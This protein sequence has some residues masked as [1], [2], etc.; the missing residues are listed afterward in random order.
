MARLPLPRNPAQAV[1]AGFAAAILIG[2]AL[3]M[4]PG[5]RAGAGG[6]PLEVAMFTA[7]SAVCVTG[8]T[9]VDTAVYWSDLGHAII[10]LLIQV[11]G[12]GIVTSAALL[13]ILVG[14]RIGLRTSILTQAEAGALRLGD[15]RRV[16]LGVAVLTLAAEVATTLV[17]AGRFWLGYHLG[18]G[19]ALWQGAFH[20]ISAYNN[21][22][23]ALFSDSLVGFATDGWILV[24]IALAVIIGSLGF[25]VWLDLWRLPA[26]PRRWSLHT[27][28]TLVATA[29]LIVLGTAAMWLFEWNHPETLGGVSVP[30]RLLVGFFNAVTPRTAGFNAVDYADLEPETLFVTDILMFIGGGAGSTAGGIKTATLALL[31]LMV[32]AEIRGRPEVTAFG[33]RIPGVAQRQALSVALLGIAAVVAATL[34]LMAVSPFRLSEALFEVLSAFGT[35]GLSTGI[36]ADLPTSG[37]ALLGAMMFVGRVGPLTLGVALLMRESRPLYQYPEERPIIA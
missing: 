32:L 14:R 24:T 16:V 28:L 21:A 31:A 29:I 6:A 26:A 4:L 5:A 27:K 15:V 7:T 8:L 12:F 18:P 9:V 36:T 1:V 34:A 30:G 33:R 11:G 17:L 35:V 22:G 37:Q 25:P 19:E 2:T 3:L 20:A 23:F 13:V 10:A